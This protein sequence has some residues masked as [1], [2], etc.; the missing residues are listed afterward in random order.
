MTKIFLR[1]HTS[2]LISIDIKPHLRTP[3][4]SCIQLS[5]IFWLCRAPA[6]LLFSKQAIPAQ[7]SIAASAKA[8]IYFSS[9]IPEFLGH[10][11]S[12]S[13][14]NTI[15]R[16]FLSKIRGIQ[17]A[18]PPTLPHRLQI[19]RAIYATTK[20]TRITRSTLARQYV[21]STVDNY[22]LPGSL[23]VREGSSS[24]RILV[25]PRDRQ[26]HHFWVIYRHLL[27]LIVDIICGRHQQPN[28]RNKTS[29]AAVCVSRAR[30]S[31]KT[32]SGRQPANRKRRRK[33]ANR[34]KIHFYSRYFIVSNKTTTH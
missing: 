26:T 29:Q 21:Y 4:T 6:L 20:N 10:H 13:P 22:N 19:L 18:T 14:G 25:S 24:E 17:N 15:Q 28:K 30:Y 27:L 7:R 12:L 11:T 23:P 8:P 1:F 34:P 33:E 16:F 32:A 3:T 2:N 5:I 9:P 31:E